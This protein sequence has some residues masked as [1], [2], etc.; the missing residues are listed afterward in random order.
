MHPEKGLCTVVGV[1]GGTTEVRQFSRNSA[2]TR[3]ATRSLEPLPDPAVPI[4]ELH[5]ATKGW[6]QFSPADQQKLEDAY[7]AGLAAAAAGAAGGSSGAWE[8]VVYHNGNRAVVNFHEMMMADGRG[9]TRVV[10]RRLKGQVAGPVQPLD[11]LDLEE[12]CRTGTKIQV[13]GKGLATVLFVVENNAKVQLDIQQKKTFV[14]L[15]L[16]YSSSA[17]LEAEEAL[18]GRRCGNILPSPVSVSKT[19]IARRSFRAAALTSRPRSP[20]RCKGWCA[21]RRSRRR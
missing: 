9:H 21:V 16:L 14:A 17:D 2:L 13:K 8:H 5:T 7:S 20:S 11:I 15:D 4:W 12:A 19:E 6:H 10:R 1:K 18:A 3:L